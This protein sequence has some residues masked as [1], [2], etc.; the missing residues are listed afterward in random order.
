M[1]YCMDRHLSLALLGALCLTLLAPMGAAAQIPIDRWV[2][3]APPAPKEAVDSSAF[4]PDAAVR[5]FENLDGYARAQTDEILHENGASD[6]ADQ[7]NADWKERTELA[8]CL[9]MLLEQQTGLLLSAQRG[10][11]IFRQMLHSENSQFGLV[12]PPH[13]KAVGDYAVQAALGW[14]MYSSALD[15]TYFLPVSG[16]T[17]AFATEPLGV[18]AGQVSVEKAPKWTFLYGACA[19]NIVTVTAS[20]PGSASG[21]TYQHTFVFASFNDPS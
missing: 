2:D 13:Y 20:Q 11:A 18:Y 21:A 7:D 19:R 4:S 5:R 3:R 10:Q 15:A 9:T 14:A 12:F 8:V 1:K 6:A 17:F 16:A